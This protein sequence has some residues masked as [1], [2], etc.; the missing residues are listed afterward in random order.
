M[1]DGTSRLALGTANF[2]LEY[3]VKNLS[4]RLADQ[5][6]I[7]IVKCAK[8]GG[9]KTVDTAQAYGDSEQRLGSLKCLD[10]QII[11]K[12]G[13][14][15]EQHYGKGS[16]LDTVYESLK[17]LNINRL[18]GLLL[19]RPEALLGLHGDDIISELILLKNDKLVE[20]IGISIYSPSILDHLSKFIDFD[21]VQAPFNVFDQRI[22]TSGWAERLKEKGTEVHIRSVFLQGLL[23][24][25]PY[26]LPDWF[27]TRW[28][29]IFSNWFSFQSLV[30]CNV[31]ELTL[32]HALKQ[33][34]VDKIIIG[35][36]N[37][38]QLEG[39]LEIEKNCNTFPDP[40]FTVNDLELLEPSR[41]KIN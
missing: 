11:T 34:W 40:N 35:I 13:V 12:V 20:K 14:E 6:I 33:T 22:L 10:M 1:H 2:G 27:K 17:R 41:W 21:I 8:E 32:G 24:M 37:S 16:L 39:L 31:E 29:T 26:E 4:K 38:H 3:G 28:A 19:H 5:E 36:D 25:K 23:L 30:A 7:D 9:I 18:D 15:F